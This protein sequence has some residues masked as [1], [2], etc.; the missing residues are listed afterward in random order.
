MT[1]HDCLLAGSGEDRRTVRELP[2]GP[3]DSPALTILAS[4]PRAGRSAESP[5]WYG[6]AD[7]VVNPDGSWSLRV[8][9]LFH[10]NRW[11][12]W[13]TVRAP[14]K[15]RPADGWT[16]TQIRRARQRMRRAP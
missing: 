7:F 15:V 4:V 10:G 9:S 6:A 11:C 5:Q 14:M 8:R 3:G 16:A 1:G 13:L 2:Y 12:E